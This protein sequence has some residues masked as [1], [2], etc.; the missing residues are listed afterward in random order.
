MHGAEKS[1]S[2]F[3]AM[4]PDWHLAARDADGRSGDKIVTWDPS[5]ASFK[6][7]GFVGGI[8]LSGFVRGFEHK[9][10]IINL[11]APCH[12]RLSFWNGMES[13]GIL[14]LENLLIDGY[15]NLVLKDDE[16]WGS[17]GRK[18]NMAGKIME[19]F[20]AHNLCDLMLKDPGPTWYNG[21]KGSYI[22]CK[23]IDR[24]V[25]K[26]SL[27]T[28]MG[29]WGRQSETFSSLTK[30]R[31]SWTGVSRRNLEGTRSNSIGPGSRILLL[32]PW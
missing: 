7:Y 6:A 5:N 17:T 31:F 28:R 4:V 10:H 23:R 24:F 14:Q 26:S 18:D 21:R 13:C 15:F 8:L 27:L 2:V 12:D 32:L 22:I 25:V 3:R 16:I 30:G 1:I 19:I 11:Y 20:K 9:I 29:D